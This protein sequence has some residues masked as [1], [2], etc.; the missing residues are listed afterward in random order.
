VAADAAAPDGPDA[1][2]GGTSLAAAS[3][4]AGRLAGGAADAGCATAG[5]DA[6]IDDVTF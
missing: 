6:I 4:T 5:L 2:G 1:A 3:V